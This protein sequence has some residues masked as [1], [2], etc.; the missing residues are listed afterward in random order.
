MR[1]NDP[2]FL[3][4]L[5]VRLAEE[6]VEA[7]VFDAHASSLFPGVLDTLGTRVMVDPDVAAKAKR[8]LADVEAG[9]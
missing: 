6:G 7:M 4:A 3:S 2:V 9:R 1:T 5:L 8:I